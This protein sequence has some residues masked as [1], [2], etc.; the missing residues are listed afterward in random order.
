MLYDRAR[1]NQCAMAYR[2]RVRNACDYTGEDA[3]RHRADQGE[4]ANPLR[5]VE[6][7]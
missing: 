3:R 2:G 6:S 4:G 1:C 5:L 7:T